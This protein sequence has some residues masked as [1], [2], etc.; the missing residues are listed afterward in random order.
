MKF[1]VGDK[2]IYTEYLN[3]RS[4]YI[5]RKE[6]KGTITKCD[7]DDVYGKYEIKIDDYISEYNHVNKYQIRLD[8][9]RT[10]EEKLNQLFNEI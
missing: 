7:Y 10:R 5:N 9:I 4:Y 1:K 6:Y 3:P 2:I 8:I